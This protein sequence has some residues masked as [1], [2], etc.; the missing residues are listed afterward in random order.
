MSSEPRQPSPLAL[1]IAIDLSPH[2][3]PRCVAGTVDVTDIVK[4]IAPGIDD[5]IAM[6]CSDFPKQADF[7]NAETGIGMN[8]R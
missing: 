4:A 2:I 5:S 1:R 3:I 8:D 7:P 6:A